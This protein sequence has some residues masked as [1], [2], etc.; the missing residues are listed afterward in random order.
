MEADGVRVD[1]A[2]QQP[3]KPDLEFTVLGGF[4]AHRPP[5]QARADKQLMAL[6]I[7]LPILIDS[8]GDHLGIIQVLDPATILTSRGLINL[9][10]RAHPQRL[11][12][13]VLVKLLAPHL[14]AFLGHLAQ[15]FQLQADI[16][17]L[18][19]VS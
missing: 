10:R 11:V 7:D 8:S 5:R 19:P 16:P 18:S 9:A 2:Q 13:A 4:K 6:P 14:Q 3:G 1:P 17:M 12:R 15:S